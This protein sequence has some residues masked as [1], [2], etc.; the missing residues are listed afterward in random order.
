[1][2]RKELHLSSTGRYY[3]EFLIISTLIQY[4][5]TKTLVPSRD[6]SYHSG[7]QEYSQ[8]M[9]MA[10][11]ARVCPV[12]SRTFM[13]WNANW[14]HQGVFF[15]LDDKQG[16]QGY[17]ECCWFWGQVLGAQSSL[18]SP[19]SCCA[20]V[21]CATGISE[22]KGIRGRILFLCVAALSENRK[23]RQKSCLPLNFTLM[24]GSPIV[25]ACS[26]ISVAYGVIY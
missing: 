13:N 12:R 24:R 14:V 19:W 9:G 17:S 26:S 8:K 7:L 15:L 2:A 21:G 5:V 23:E 3:N 18:P 4:L 1:M 20:M 10:G 16:G 25:L 22:G 11:I 6:Q